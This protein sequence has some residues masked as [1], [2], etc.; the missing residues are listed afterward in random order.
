MGQPPLIVFTDLDGTL[1][2]H[3]TYSFE[4]AATALGRLRDLDIPLILA[5]S[6]TA[7]EIVEIQRAIGCD[8]F[9]AI[10]ENGAGILEPVSR[11]SKDARPLPGYSA[12]QAQP[13]WDG[14]PNGEPFAPGAPPEL[15]RYPE[16][17]AALNEVSPYLRALFEGF[18]DLGPDGIAQA[19]GLDPEAARRAARRQFSEPGLFFGGPGES[20]EFLAALAKLGV[21]AR[22]GGRFL[23][24]SFGGTKADRMD[25]IAARYGNPPRLALGDAPNDIEMLEAADYGVIIANAHGTPLPDLPGEAAGLI[26]RTSLPGPLGWNSAVLDLLYQ[27]KL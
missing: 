15:G 11:D 14:A 7:A 23:T 3:E 17:I 13:I 10:V 27:L 12:D 20:D 21:R 19:T 18:Y 9:P 4:P 6:K 8:G 25:E 26:R 22:R 2:D 5:S 1:L 24:L 16:L